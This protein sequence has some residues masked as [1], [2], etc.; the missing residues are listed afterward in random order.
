MLLS[1]S[2]IERYLTEIREPTEETYE[3]P[4][5][6]KIKTD[7]KK[8]DIYQLGSHRLMCGDA[9]NR[10]DVEA[11]MNGQKADLLATD[12]PYGISIVNDKGA[13]G[14]ANVAKLTIYGDFE[15]DKL[16]DIKPIL[17]LDCYNH[18]VI[19][20]GNYFADKL[21]I[22]NSWLIW[23]KRAGEASWF[24]DFELAWSNL[25][26]GPKLFQFIWQGMIRQGPRIKRVHPTQKPVELM[27]WCMT[28]VNPS[29]TVLDLFGGSG[30]TLIACE[31]TNRICYMMEI[32]PRYCQIII[33]RWQAYTGKKAVKI[34]EKL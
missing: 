26:T 17:S 13:V 4:E 15:G 25:G 31:Q 9:T 11:L 34:V 27:R 5:I 8:G 21:P 30:S 19:W 10:K 33:N 22:T 20:G 3:I 14:K 28:L 24:S 7:I 18:A 1:D 2:Q 23:D 16:F 29:Q 32:E 6:D 12:P